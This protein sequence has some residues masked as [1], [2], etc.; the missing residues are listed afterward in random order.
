[1]HLL[2]KDRNAWSGLVLSSISTR[3][4]CATE[5]SKMAHKPLVHQPALGRGGVGLDTSAT[6]IIVFMSLSAGHRHDTQKLKLKLSST[7]RS[8]QSRKTMSLIIIVAQVVSL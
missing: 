8:L 1:M 2:R 5:R 4:P 6:A 3:L 7:S